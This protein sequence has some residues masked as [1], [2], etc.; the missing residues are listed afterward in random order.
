[1]VE[2]GIPT[3]PQGGGRLPAEHSGGLP[4]WNGNDTADVMCAISKG[5]IV[6]PQPAGNVNCYSHTWDLS[7]MLHA[8]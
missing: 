7:I 2:G 1:M 6:A 5:N 4:T 8:G 3:S